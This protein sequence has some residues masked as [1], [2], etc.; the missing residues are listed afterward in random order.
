MFSQIRGDGIRN[1]IGGGGSIGRHRDGAQGQH[2]L[3]HGIL[4][5]GN[6]GHCIACSSRRMGMQHGAN[7]RPLLITAQMHF[8]FRGRAVSLQG[9]QY[10]SLPVNAHKLFR[11]DEAFADPRR[12][13][14]K[15]AVLQLRGNIS[16]IR[17]HPAELPHFVT[18]ITDLLS[19]CKITQFHFPKLLSVVTISS[20]LNDSSQKRNRK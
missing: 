8:D 7:V 18:N 12:G 2:R 20:I 14:H 1:L 6:V 19:Q 11:S 4:I 17:R 15:A 9:F 13:R 3:Y 5:Q 10:I 16:V